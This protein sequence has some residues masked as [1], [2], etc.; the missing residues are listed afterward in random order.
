MKE[1]LLDTSIC[2]ALFRGNKTVEKRLN[3]IGREHC[4]IS[5][6][7]LAELRFGAYKSARIEE[8]LELINDFV[9]EIQ[10][11][12]LADCID[13]YAKEKVKLQKNGTPI[14]D[15][16]LFIGCAAKAAGTTIVTHNVKHFRH[17]EDLSI[18]DWLA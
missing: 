18:E 9:R 5:D 8:N 12:P 10:V 7:V 14:E 17:I 6:I 1:Y 3:Q 11:L 13:I 4:Y 2:V 16:D 15:F